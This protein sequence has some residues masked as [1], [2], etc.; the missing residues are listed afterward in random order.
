[1]PT[2]AVT[3]NF[4]FSQ[5]WGITDAI[6]L[7]FATIIFNDTDSNTII[8]NLVDS[9]VTVFNQVDE[10]IAQFSLEHFLS[11]VFRKKDDDN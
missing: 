4:M 9:I 10:Q 8:M 6:A 7:D 5:D 3:A 1:M 2:A 11:I